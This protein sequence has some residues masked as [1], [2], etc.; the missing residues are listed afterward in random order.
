[1]CDPV[2]GAV[3]A[4][5]I[6]TYASATAAAVGAGATIYGAQQSS[7]AQSRAADAV[8]QQ[9]L[10][11][12][13]AQ[14]D[15]FTQ[16]MNAT[17]EQS[18]AQFATGQREIQ[19]RTT[20]AMATRA[21]QMSAL[22][23]Q[24]Q[25]LNAENQSA[26]QIR[27]AAD[28]RAQD[29]L[30]QTS[31]PTLDQSQTGAQDRA[32]ALLAASQAPGPTGPVATDPSGSG[33]STS[34]NDPV[35]KTAIAR[36]MGI[37]AANIR[38]YGSDIAKVASYGQP[39]QDVNLAIKGNQTNIMPE[40]MAAKL[41]AGGSQIRL[42][43]SQIAYRNA[44]D[45][46]GAVDQMIQQRAAGENTFAGLR[47][48]NET[49]SANLGQSDA[50]TRASNVS[51]QA[52][53]DAAWQQQVAGLFSGIGNLGLYAAGRFGPAILPGASGVPTPTVNAPSAPNI[54]T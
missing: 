26:E 11:T 4:T 52:K 28:Q 19:D 36:R 54:I 9:N 45:Y 2:T 27:A 6:A 44:T 34:T 25:T 13:Q 18:D 8:R 12:T 31:G 39:L 30:S 49:G 51:A 24:N 37:A 46:G 15:A 48:G 21:A 7:A 23:R 50:D 35:M 16:R 43:P 10:A 32:A 53:A 29:L 5:S 14:N 22:D 38:Q 3:T 40:E 17:R 42:L 20:A 41:L 47:F 1:M 33:A